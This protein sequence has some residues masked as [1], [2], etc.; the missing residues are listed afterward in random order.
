MKIEVI[1]KV[2][3]TFTPIT[4]QFTCST[5][6]EANEMAILFNNADEIDWDVTDNVVKNFNELG[7]TIIKQLEERG[8]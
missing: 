4:I 6:T 5:F 2:D 8:F 7:E 1:K 3:T